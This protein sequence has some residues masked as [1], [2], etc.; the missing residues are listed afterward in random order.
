MIAD[1]VSAET[2]PH[3]RVRLDAAVVRFIRRRDVRGVASRIRNFYTTAEDQDC[4]RLRPPG[5]SRS[6]PQN[7][8][9]NHQSIPEMQRA[10]SVNSKI[11]VTRHQLN[12]FFVR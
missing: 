6:W 7:W 3:A 11:G 2:G 1:D 5:F 12:F 9:Q 4:L 8:P 10:K